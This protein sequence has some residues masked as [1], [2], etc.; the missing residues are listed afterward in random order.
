[1]KSW[2]LNIIFFAVYLSNPVMGN[3]NPWE[4][5]HKLEQK[6]DYAG[7]TQAIQGVLKNN[8]QHEYAQTRS[9]WLSYL[10]KDYSTSVSHYK[11]AIEINP[12]S[13]DAK[14]GITLPL[15][16]QGRWRE[17]ANYSKEVLIVSPH[18]YYAEIRLMACEEALLQWDALLEHAQRV[19][20]IYPTDATVL[21][22]LARAASVSGNN[23][24]AIDT[25]K[26]VLERLPGNL[27]AIRFLASN[28]IK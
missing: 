22:Y 12:K 26:D 24:K 28:N 27:E 13:L 10:Q 23:N 9:G 8:F 3:E 17:A 1:M 14:L 7:A 5:S 20:R 2:S 11:T 16:A 18:H 6:A 21:I 19:S 25:Y 4:I 15:M